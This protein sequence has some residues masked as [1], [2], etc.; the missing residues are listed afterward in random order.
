MSATAPHDAP[1]TGDGA[2]P[3]VD[4][5]TTA[6]SARFAWRVM[7]SDRTTWAIAAGL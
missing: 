7:S 2:G 1:V 6:S 4:V 3:T 5:P